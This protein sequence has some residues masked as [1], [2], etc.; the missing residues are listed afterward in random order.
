MDVREKCKNKGCLFFTGLLQFPGEQRAEKTG[1]SMCMVEA[2]SV[3]GFPFRVIGP[4]SGHLVAG[5]WKYQYLQAF[6]LMLD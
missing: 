1:S 3:V 6:Y 4:G 5:T 2:C